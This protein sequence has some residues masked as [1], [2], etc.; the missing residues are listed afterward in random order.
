MMNNRKK[1]IIIISL[2]GLLVILTIVFIVLKTSHT[3]SPTQTGTSSY[4]DPASGTTVSSPN[5]KTPEPLSGYNGVVYLGFSSLLDDGLSNDQFSN[6][7]LHLAAF[8]ENS[9][10]ESVKVTQVSLQISSITQTNNPD[11]GIIVL[12]ANL[13]INKTI[14]QHII[15]HY[16]VLGHLVMDL[17]DTNNTIVYSSVDSD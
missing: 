10:V 8:Y 15:L 3:S 4:V 11:T 6:V 12:K 2:V 13:I 16:N 7:K 5:G 17:T 14:T 9:S 1:L